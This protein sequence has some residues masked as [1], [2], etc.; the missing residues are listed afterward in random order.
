MGVKVEFLNDKHGVRAVASGELTGEAFIAAVRQVN[1]FAATVAPIWYTFFDCERLTAISVNTGDLAAAALC[2]IEA[3]KRSD[4][5][6]VVAIYASDEYSYGLARIY[7]TFIEQ[8]GWEVWVFRDRGEA[9]AWLRAR[10][11]MK[12]GITIEVV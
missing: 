6:R 1:V 3:A 5:E 10:A 8:T 12:H 4:A 2:A 7:T 11:A 9:V